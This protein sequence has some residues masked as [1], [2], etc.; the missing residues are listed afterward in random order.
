MDFLTGMAFWV[1]ILLVIINT[2]LVIRTDVVIHQEGDD[3]G[4][5]KGLKGDD[6]LCRTTQ[7]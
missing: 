3:D 4:E 5:K 1:I 7:S 6:K 2:V